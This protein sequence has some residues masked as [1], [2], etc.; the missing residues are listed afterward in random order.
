MV[1]QRRK[2]K[3]LADIRGQYQPNHQEYGFPTEIQFKLSDNGKGISTTIQ[4]SASSVKGNSGYII[5]PDGTR[6]VLTASNQSITLTQPGTYT[7]G[8]SFT[9]FKF[10][11]SDSTLD[12]SMTPASVWEKA[13]SNVPDFGFE[14]FKNVHDLSGVPAGLKLKSLDKTFERT[15][16]TTDI[17]V[18]D[19]SLVTSAVGTFLNSVVEVTDNVSAWDVSNVTNMSR[20]FEGATVYNGDISIWDVRNVT[21]M[22]HMFKG[23]S[24]FNQDLSAWGPYVGNVTNMNSMF[25]S[26]TQYNSDITNWDVSSVTDMGSMFNKAHSF[27]Q[28]IGDWDVSNVTV[29]SSMFLGTNQF[30]QDLTEWCVRTIATEPTDFSTGSALFPK[31][32]PFWGTC[33]S[34]FNGEVIFI[35]GSNLRMEGTVSVPGQIIEPDGNIVNIGPGNWTHIGKVLGSYSLPM[36]DMERLVF[37]GNVRNVFDFDPNFYTGNLTNMSNMFL[38]ANEFNGDISNWDTSLVTDMTNM[39]NGST[40]M[41]GDISSWCVTQIASK[42]KDFDKGAGFEGNPYLL[43]KWEA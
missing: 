11:H 1:W 21:D 10:T 3:F 7:V 6:T 25:K 37:S 23:A 14:L 24:T 31:N 29:M 33:S 9:R 8:E 15:C 40:S 2:R 4:L 17:G 41:Q 16:P 22:S 39:F 13:M 19:T 35:S 34:P 36:E 30:N 5:Y 43:P 18:I 26:A 28:D 12:A 42:P 27:N 32:K 20:M 38:R